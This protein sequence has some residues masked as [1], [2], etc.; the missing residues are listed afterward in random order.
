M[1][2]RKLVWVINRSPVTTS[3]IIAKGLCLPHF[4]IMR[5]VDRYTDELLALSPDH[6]ISHTW[7]EVPGKEGETRALAVF[8]NEYQAAFILNLPFKIGQTDKARAF[9]R[10][11][12]KAFFEAH[13]ELKPVTPARQ[14]TIADLCRMMDAPRGV[15]ISLLNMAGMLKRDKEGNPV[16]PLTLSE[17]GLD[18]KYGNSRVAEL[19]FKDG[20][21]CTEREIE[22][23]F[24]PGVLELTKIYADLNTREVSHTAA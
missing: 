23:M 11:L 7:T 24:G 9:R 18:P 21:P 8:L 4:E 16:Q 15:V 19:V 14:Y 1:K 5:A 10:L 2:E 3:G 13:Q 6:V 22:P 20:S 12:N 17:K